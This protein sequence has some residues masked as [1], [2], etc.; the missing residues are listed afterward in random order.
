MSSG[1]LLESA[2]KSQIDEAASAHEEPAH[3]LHRPA[4]AIPVHVD[5]SMQASSEAIVQKSTASPSGTL[6]KETGS[7]FH[8]AASGTAP[9][10]DDAPSSSD[11]SPESVAVIQRT[12]ANV[13]D[14][15]L[16]AFALVLIISLIC[17][18][19]P[20]EA[21]DETDVDADDADGFVAFAMSTSKRWICRMCCCNRGRSFARS[22]PD[23][24]FAVYKSDVYKQK[25]LGSFESDTAPASSLQ[26][27]QDLPCTYVRS[28]LIVH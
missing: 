24:C 22:C 20:W 4:L 16:A 7:H 1:V 28:G 5:K 21:A 23:A 15:C 13:I 3:L 11:P 25:S 2:A 17:F 26:W 9:R 8:S 27:N 18:R 6:A 19:L 12:V 10:A 14:N